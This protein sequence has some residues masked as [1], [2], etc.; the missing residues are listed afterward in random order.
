MGTRLDMI[1]VFVNDLHQMVSFY[2][3][4]LG[5]ETDWAR[6]VCRVQA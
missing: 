2:R 1:G 3:D 5:F 4:V 6:P